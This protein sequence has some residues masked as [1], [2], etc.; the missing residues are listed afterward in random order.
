MAETWDMA[1]SAP[2]WKVT[3]WLVVTK[4]E[5]C[6]VIS[7]FLLTSMTACAG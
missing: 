3:D 2:G 1:T 7:R 5:G 4:A 6:E